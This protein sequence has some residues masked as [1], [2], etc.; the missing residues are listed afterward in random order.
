MG[1]TMNHSIKIKAFDENDNYLGLFTISCNDR[2]E[3]TSQNEELDN[4]SL[5]NIPIIEDID[6]TSPILY[7]KIA[8]N[9]VNIFLLEA[10][11]YQVSFEPNKKDLEAFT[12]FKYENSP[13]TLMNVPGFYGGFLNFTSYV[14]KTFFDIKKNGKTIYKLPV[15]VRSKKIKYNE[16][17]P[18]MIGDLS[19]YSSG[20]IFEMNSPLY[21]SFELNENRSD[22]SYED[23]MLLEY[24]FRP[25]NL[26]ST[27]EYLSNNLYTLLENQ[28]E[29]VPTSMASN[30]G[31]N[32][33]IDV[34]SNP[35]NLYKTKESNSLWNQRT[36][37]YIPI[38]IN[39]TK[40][41]D[42]IDV[43]EN[44]FYK[45]FLEFIESLIISLINKTEEGYVR[46]KLYEYKEEISYYLSQR[47]FKDISIMDYAPLNSQV[48]QKKEGY[49]DILEYYLMFEFGF[50]MNWSDIT[51][52]F[53]GYEKKLS[54][55]YEY[56]C[57]FKLI[58]IVKELTGSKINFEDVFEIDN[59]NWNIHLKEG[60]IKELD[61]EIDNQLI[62]INLMYNKTFNKDKGTYSVEMRP[63]YTLEF[64]INNN[65]YKIHFDAK[66][67]LNIYDESFKNQDIIKMHS[68]KDAIE[69]TLGAYVL[70]P[71]EK[72]E[73]FEENEL[74][75]VGAFP[76]N[77]G[78]DKNE[79]R[80]L[81]K[82]IDN[83][84]E[85]LL[86]IY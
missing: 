18:A 29:E 34:F 15:E 49:R 36:N 25:E 79:K 75:S 46:D 22:T 84:L 44:R 45:N 64:I 69:N 10:T 74:E 23:F 6:N 83:L 12:L 52:D 61:F 1:H 63:D 85:K 33:L 20:L 39:E 62:K 11:Q 42:T 56:W 24:L 27:F 31:P 13:L 55:L 28:I 77:P 59:Q 26:P 37:G 81:V 8:V 51:N 32:E 3:D 7:S 76:L 54:T 70:Y 17:Y 65:N 16:Q 41:V 58:H 53:R 72:K 30:V 82:F 38:K 67:R 50:K 71:G 66:Y 21:Q 19:K 9:G 14:G 60:I 86:Y 73:I 57:Y 47:Y 80:I 78:D 35:R 4:I 68:Y 43:P 5:E 40:H 2:E 48:L